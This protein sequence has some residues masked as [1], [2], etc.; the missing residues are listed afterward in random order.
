MKLRALIH[1]HAA[2]LACAAAF[3]AQGYVFIRR[4]GV[5][6]DESLFAGA[7][8]RPLEVW[9]SVEV[10]GRRVPLGLDAYL[11]CLKAWLYAPLLK[12]WRPS[13]FSLRVP[14]LLAGAV[15]IWLLFRLM[16]RWAGPGAAAAACAL[17]ATES[18]FVLTTVLDWGPV[19]LQHLLTVLALWLLWR[20]HETGR[21]WRLALG[22]LVCGL[23]LWDKATFLWMLAGLAVGAAVAFRRELGRLLT[24]RNLAVGVCGLLV[25]ASPLIYSSLTSPE[26]LQRAS[27]G[28]STEHYLAKAAIL[29]RTL[30]G[31]GL[32]GYLTRLEAPPAP[33]AP[34]T[35]VEKIALAVSR[36]LGRPDSHYQFWAAAVALLLLPLLWKSPARRLMVFSLAAFLVAWLSMAATA[37]GGMS[38][39]H[40]VLLWPLPQILTGAAASQIPRLLPRRGRLLA[41]VLMG[42]VCL[43]GLAVTNHY[44]VQLIER[45][46]PVAWTDASYP[47]WERLNTM[48]IRDLYALDWGIVGPVRWLGGG[49]LPLRGWLPMEPGW[50]E[51]Q[52]AAFRNVVSEPDNCYIAHTAGSEFFP[53]QRQALS[54]FAAQQG[55][56]EEILSVISDRHGRPVFELFRY[57]PAGTEREAGPR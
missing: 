43:S 49:R 57:V 37:R 52:W 50:Q 56:R 8:L 26:R 15:I 17:L 51:R 53:G 35:R 5:Q 10:F 2:A 46:T 7:L 21:L 6:H 29:A 34:E 40:I 20:F 32:F 44:L 14:V 48:R 18:V 38:V 28:L 27:G 42:V 54:R 13:V 39:H 30:D 3:F 1:E 55:F 9:T 22:S 19:A 12:L 45:G 16:R 25:G 4:V 33:Q 41:V 47:L 31:S 24:A 23:A 36:G 11:G